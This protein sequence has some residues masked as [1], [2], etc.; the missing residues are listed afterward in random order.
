M[1]FLQI[2]SSGSSKPSGPPDPA[3]LAKVRQSIHQA[4]EDGT[5]LATG[6]LG[7]RATVAARVIRQDGK[8]TVEDPPSGDG[9]MAGGGYSLNEFPSKEEAIA[10]AKAKLD[11]MGDGVVELIQVSEMYPSAG[12]KAG[13]PQVAS[14]ADYPAGVVPYLS[15]DGASDA[16]A[17]YQRAFGAR[18]VARMAAEDGKRVMHCHL[19]INGGAFML[20]DNF[21]EMGASPVQ[22]S[23]SYT[24]QLIVR[25]GDYWWRRAIEAGCKEKLP[26]AVAPWGDKYGQLVDPFGVTWALNMPAKR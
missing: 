5:L 1:R 6:S 7:K 16:A 19:E 3:H 18:E 8:L 24:M 15:I 14:S 17:F 20:A 10:Q 2:V 21:A 9:W 11:L 13:A 12:T 22:R 4:I 23:A 25:D 26:F